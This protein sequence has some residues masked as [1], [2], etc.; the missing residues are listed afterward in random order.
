MSQNTAE[1]PRT[2]N[3]FLM[4]KLWLPLHEKEK[5]LKIACGRH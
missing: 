4:I 1:D 3:Y 2:Q 5:A